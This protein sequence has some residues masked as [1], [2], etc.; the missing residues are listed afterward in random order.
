MTPHRLVMGLKP[1][2]LEEAVHQKFE[3]RPV[4][5]NLARNEQDFAQALKN[6]HDISLAAMAARQGEAGLRHMFAIIAKTAPLVYLRMKEPESSSGAKEG[7]L[8]KFTPTV[9][10][11]RKLVR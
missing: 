3:A 6:Y 7:L 10:A 1:R 4:S 8:V 5:S 9:S 11:P 2:I